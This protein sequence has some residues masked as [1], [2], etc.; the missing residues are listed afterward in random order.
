M[1]IK[2][3]S[4]DW[5]RTNNIPILSRTPLPIGPHGRFASPQTGLYHTGFTLQWLHGRLSPCR[6][7][8]LQNKAEAIGFEPMQSLN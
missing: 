4:R 7:A 8:C 3:N 6:R 5:I 2:I 1:P